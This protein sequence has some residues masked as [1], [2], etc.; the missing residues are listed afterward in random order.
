[1]DIQ[2]CSVHTGISAVLEEFYV[3]FPSSQPLTLIQDLFPGLE[4]IFKGK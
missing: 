4:S 1:M 3:L 2:S